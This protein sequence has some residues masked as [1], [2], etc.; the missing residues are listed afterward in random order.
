M[1]ALQNGQCLT[2]PNADGAFYGMFGWLYVANYTGETTIEG[3][4][5]SLFSYEFTYGDDFYGNYLCM[6][7]DEP[8]QLNQTGAG[9]AQTMTYRNFNRKV[10][11]AALQS[12]TVCD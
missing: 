5:C 11:P 4:K 1:V 6:D 9:T 2:V 3:R 7:G 12:P 10:D 8:V